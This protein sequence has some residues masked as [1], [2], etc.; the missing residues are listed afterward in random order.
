MPLGSRKSSAASNSSTPS[1][2][3]AT[4]QPGI[5]AILT[6][7]PPAPQQASHSVESSPSSVPSCSTGRSVRGFASVRRKGKRGPTLGKRVRRTIRSYNGERLHVYVT[8]EMRAFCG[9]NATPIA[10]ELGS[11]IRRSCAIIGFPHSWKDVEDGLQSAIIQAVQK[12]K[13]AGKKNRHFVPE[14][15]TLGARKH[16]L[17][18]RSFPAAITIEADNRKERIQRREEERRQRQ[19][20]GLEEGHEEEHEEEE[21]GPDFCALYKASRT[22][23]DT[24]GWVDPKCKEYY[25]KMIAIRDEAAQSGTPL[26]GEEISRRVLGEARYYIRGFGVGPVPSSYSFKS[27]SSA[28]QQI[29]EKYK[30]DLELLREER[31]REREEDQ[32]RW[33]EER[34]R[35][36]EEQRR[37]DEEY[38]SEFQKLTALLMSHINKG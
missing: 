3:I 26:T 16:T 23:K 2:R 29:S 21:E 31:R 8:R 34:R 11:Q 22:L 5:V 33:E 7:Q 15:Q 27:N 28:I 30:A 25:D 38:R 37:R 12:R 36:D 24:G 1:P 6:P 14:G 20:E 10:N 19:E 32:M 18:S 17:G 4:E 9:K 13:E 35:R